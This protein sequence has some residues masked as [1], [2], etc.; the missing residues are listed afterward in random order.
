MLWNQ[1]VPLART[2][3]EQ[4]LQHTHPVLVQEFCLDPNNLG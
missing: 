4:M 2:I 3:T 1:I